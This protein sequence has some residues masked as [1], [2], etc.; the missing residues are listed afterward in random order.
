MDISLISDWFKSMI[1]S[2]NQ[3]L[4]KNF[5]LGRKIGSGSFGDIYLGSNVYNNEDVAIKLESTKTRHPQLSIESRI[6]KYCILLY[7]SIHS[8]SRAMAGGIGIPQIK[9]SGSEGDY[10]VLVS[11][12]TLFLTAYAFWSR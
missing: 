3:K 10:N 9:W 6:Y 11:L 2:A 12:K 1:F 5:S 7:F 8:D 4:T